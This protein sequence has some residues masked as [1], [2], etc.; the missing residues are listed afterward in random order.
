M[1]I[2]AG[3]SLLCFRAILVLRMPYLLLFTPGYT[4][5]VNTELVPSLGRKPKV[6]LN[7]HVSLEIGLP[8]FM[9]HR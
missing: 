3:C 5:Q 2:I 8:F 4:N 9:C 7:L 1:A 6:W